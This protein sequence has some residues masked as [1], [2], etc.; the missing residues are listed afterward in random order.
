M[1]A[2]ETTTKLT[3]S[4]VF[5]VQP[6]DSTRPTMEIEPQTLSSYVEI[7]NIKSNQDGLTLSSMRN[8][9]VATMNLPRLEFQD[10]SHEEPARPDFPFRV[11]GIMDQLRASNDFAV[12][13]AGI[14]FEARADADSGDAEL[15]SQDMRCF[16]KED[17]LVGTRYKTAGASLRFW[18]SHDVRLFDLRIEPVGNHYEGQGYFCRLH[19]HIASFPESGVTEEW[20]TENLRKE[21]NDFKTVLAHINRQAKEKTH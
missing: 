4:V 6:T 2:L 17:L 1:I 8:Q 5:I 3:S 14:T 16:L 9:M 15:P 12:E 19:V 7:P 20:L 10:L 13:A 21:Y 18:Y 11:S